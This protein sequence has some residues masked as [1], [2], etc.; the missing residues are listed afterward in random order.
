MTSPP[1]A[2]IAA[3]MKFIDCI[4]RGDIDGLDALITDQHTLHV[5][6]ETPLI[7]RSAIIEAWR[8]Y[9]SSFPDYVIHPHE[10]SEANEGV[11]VL[12]HTTGSHLGLP[13]HEERQITLIWFAR[14]EHGRL[15]LWRLLDD[16][17]HHRREFG[18]DIAS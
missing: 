4:N 2:D 15:R 5:F 1:K 13:D 17:Y 12:G 18:F 7:G 9:V 11:A 10:F 16:T 14:V 6:N 8:S 3:V